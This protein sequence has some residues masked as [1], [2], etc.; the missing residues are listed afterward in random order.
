MQRG[1]LVVIV[2]VMQGGDWELKHRR[3]PDCWRWVMLRLLD[4]ISVVSC[5]D[6][7]DIGKP[8]AY[9]QW[10]RASYWTAAHPVHPIFV[11]LLRP[12]PR[13]PPCNIS[14]RSSLKESV[15]SSVMIKLL[16]PFVSHPFPLF[17]NIQSYV[18]SSSS[19]LFFKAVKNRSLKKS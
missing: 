4:Q 1:D 9:L 8:T 7:R 14:S 13:I 12:C 6:Q 2:D 16:T 19:P 15:A 17:S 11:L 3:W 10:R 5:G 18:P